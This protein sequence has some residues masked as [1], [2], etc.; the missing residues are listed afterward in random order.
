[1]LLPFMN[2]HCCYLSN[3][4]AKLIGELEVVGGNKIYLKN[5]KLYADGFRLPEHATQEL[6]EKV[7]PLLDFDKFIFPVQLDSVSN[8]DKSIL[9]FTKDKP[10]P[11]ESSFTWLIPLLKCRISASHSCREQYI[12]N[13]D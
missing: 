5:C 6:I 9:I 4:L 2:N 12:R 10:E 1:M 13:L 8:D 3:I 7:Q 11:F